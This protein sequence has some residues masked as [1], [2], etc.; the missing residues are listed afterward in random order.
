MRSLELAEKDKSGLNI[1]IL[2]A[3]I[4]FQVLRGQFD[5]IE[6]RFEA[7]QKYLQRYAEEEGDGQVY[8][9]AKLVEGGIKVNWD[10]KKMQGEDFATT[11]AYM[12][13]IE[14][15]AL[16][17]RFEFEVITYEELWEFTLSELEEKA[18]KVQKK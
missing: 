16:D 11:L 17:S 1:S 2:F 3:D 6:M 18:K 7:T 8:Q 4:I 9:Y 13:T 5:D 15:N 12:S 14:G 10:Y